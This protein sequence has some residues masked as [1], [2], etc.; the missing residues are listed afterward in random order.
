MFL[1]RARNIH[2]QNMEHSSLPVTNRLLDLQRVLNSWNGFSTLRVTQNHKIWMHFVRL[3]NK[4]LAFINHQRTVLL[5]MSKMLENTNSSPDIYEQLF[6]TLVLFR[7]KALWNFS[8]WEHL[9]SPSL[10]HSVGDY[11]N[12]C[13]HMN[14]IENMLL[15][16]QAPI[17]A[18]YLV[19]NWW[20]LSEILRHCESHA[21]LFS[22]FPSIMNKRQTVRNVL[23][24]PV[25]K[26][27][28]FIEIIIILQFVASEKEILTCD[29]S[30]EPLCLLMNAAESK[31]L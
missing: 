10:W 15:N 21:I 1:S 9:G 13:I 12:H 28:G 20:K 22:C 3:A 4:Y 11:S 16:V 18:E 17:L 24:Y 19:S 5:I 23:Q 31:E 25:V 30:T 7:G 6:L 2:L 8:V 14:G 29:W 27:N 26:P